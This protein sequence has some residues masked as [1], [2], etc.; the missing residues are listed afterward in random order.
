[1]IDARISIRVQARAGRDEFVAIR[2][3]VVV[4]RVAAPAL[5]GRANRALCRLVARRLGVRTSAVT[6]VRGE[7]SRDKVLLVQGLDQPEVDAA[8]GS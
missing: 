4:V 6:I 8:L 7:H 2:E 3:G 5:D 1:V